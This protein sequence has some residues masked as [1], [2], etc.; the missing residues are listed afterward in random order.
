MLRKVIKSHRLLRLNIG[1]DQ[2]RHDYETI[3]APSGDKVMHQAHSTNTWTITASAS[4]SGAPLTGVTLTS[5][6][7]GTGLPVAT[8]PVTVSDTTSGENRDHC[9]SDHQGADADKVAVFWSPS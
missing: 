5:H 7:M 3:S 9:V 1:E 2:W 6:Y 4:R 8:L